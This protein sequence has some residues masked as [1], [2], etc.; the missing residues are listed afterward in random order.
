MKRIRPIC[1]FSEGI[2]YCHIVRPLVVA[3]WLRDLSIP[4]VVACNQRSQG[5]FAAA[6]FRTVRIVTADAGPIY[7]RLARGKWLYEF[8]DLLTYFRD[9][10]R[11]IASLDPQ[12][13]VADFRFSLLQLAKKHGI[14]AVGI[15]SASCH[16]AFPL[17]GSTPDPF[18]KPAFV[19]CPVFDA[20]QKTWLGNIARRRVVSAISE[21]LQRAS[22]ASG[23]EVLDSF[24]EY[25]SQGDVCLLSD[26]P[27]VMPLPALRPGDLYAGALIW[28]REDPLPEALPAV[29]RN[30]STIY[31]SVGTQEALPTDFL[32][33]LIR[34]LVDRGFQVIVS[35]GHRSFEIGIQHP[36]LTVVDFINESRLLPKVDLFVNAG[37]AMSVYHGLYFGIPMICLPIQADQHYHA[38]A[39]AREGVG[40]YFR[41]S[42]L[43]VGDVV[44]AAAAL[45]A[46]SSV[47][48]RCASLAKDVQTFRPKDT[49]LTRVGKLV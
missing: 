44:D 38:E 8:D 24:F 7:R 3:S 46:N 5:L 31:I 25:A 22:E 30:G 40:V 28:D 9:D 29:E 4:I 42:R 18:A 13:I 21:N 10:E 34:P 16:P 32:G 12:L 6:G 17:D 33:S 47:R 35:K 11:L 37:S 23:V 19:P 49:V 39:V 36:L 45:M 26:H 1:V 48:G 2:S 27:R 20:L 14:P 15:T 41:P 43:K